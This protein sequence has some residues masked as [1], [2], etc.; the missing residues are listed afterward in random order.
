[1][2]ID[3]LARIFPETDGEDTHNFNDGK[4]NNGESERHVEVSVHT[5]EQ[6]YESA[7][8]FS[9]SDTAYPR[10]EFKQIRCKDEQEYRDEK[11]EEFTCHLTTLESFRDV[12]VHVFNERLKQRLYTARDEAHT[13]AY[14]YAG[15]N[16]HRYHKPTHEKRVGDGHAQKVT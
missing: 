13:A 1:M 6:R 8:L 16:E 4:R 7:A 11:W 14:Q 12:V 9:E 10:N 5:A 2:E 3:K 15:D